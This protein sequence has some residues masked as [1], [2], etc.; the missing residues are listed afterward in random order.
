MALGGA[1]FEYLGK[2]TKLSAITARRWPKARMNMSRYAP[3]PDY[4]SLGAQ[5]DIEKLWQTRLS[6][7][8]APLKLIEQMNDSANRAPP[9]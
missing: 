2:K 8:S 5:P 9:T 1:I 6:A 7:D 4:G 3:V